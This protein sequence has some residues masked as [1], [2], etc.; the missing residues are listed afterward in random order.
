MT[1]P[2]SGDQINTYSVFNPLDTLAQ[3]ILG[4]FIFYTVPGTIAKIRQQLA[5]DIQFSTQHATAN[6][7]CTAVGCLCDTYHRKI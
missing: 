4:M 6:Y 1:R 2:R 7:E 3:A 5:C